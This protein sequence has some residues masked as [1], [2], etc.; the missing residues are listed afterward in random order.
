MTHTTNKYQISQRIAEKRS[1]DWTSA[2]L[3]LLAI[4]V[5]SWRLTAT[6]WTDDLIRIQLLFTLAASLGLALGL[7]RFHRWLAA[8]FTI[9]YGAFFIPWQMGLFIYGEIE[10]GERLISLWGRLLFSFNQLIGGENVEDPIL[11][12]SWLALIVWILG[13]H[14]GYVMSRH[15]NAWLATLPIAAFLVVVHTYDSHF[16]RGIWHLA[17]YMAVALLLVARAYFLDQRKKWWANGTQTSIY[18]GQDMLRATLLAAGLLVFLAWV[19][20][21]IAAEENPAQAFWD[22]ISAPWKDFR[23]EFE[24]A[25]YSLEGA[26]VTVKDYYGETLPLGRGNALASNIVLTAQ[27]IENSPTPPRFYWRDRVYS[28]YENGGWSIGDET[29]TRVDTDDNQLIFEALEGRAVGSVRITSGRN[30]ILLHTPTQPISISRNVDFSYRVNPDGTWDI[31]ALKIPFILRSGESYQVEAYFTNASVLQLQNAGNDYPDW[32]TERYLQIPPEI[33]TRTLELAAEIASGHSN[34]FDI[35]T[36][37]TEWLRENIAYIDSVSVP[38]EGFEPLDWML[39]EKREA[40]CNYYASAQIIMLRSLGIPA[41]MAV[42]YAQGDIA[43]SNLLLGGADIEKENILEGIVQDAQFFTVRQEDAHAWPEVYFPGLG[44]VEFEPT[45][46]Q[47]ALVRSQGAEDEAL[48]NV[49]SD[50]ADSFAA[51]EENE[52]V[53]DLPT[54][55]EERLAEEL[56]LQAANERRFQMI[57][58]FLVIASVIVAILWRRYRERGGKAV[59]VLIEGGINRLDL[60]TPKSLRLWAGYAQLDALPQAFM[61]INSALRRVGAAPIEGDTPKERANQL[62]KRIP[63]ISEVIERLHAQY[64]RSLYKEESIDTEGVRPAKWIIRLA[65]MAE[66]FRNWLRK[67]QEKPQ[68]WREKLGRGRKNK[69]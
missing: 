17:F 7:S 66:Q 40:F 26:P 19:T 12:L 4:L 22:R 36:A 11:F 13:S 37:I 39:F 62:V 65:S 55:L 63:R 32:V 42:G 56:A 31:S 16:S 46:N 27:V 50:E 54:V 47:V 35:S 68:G 69:E 64:E 29:T 28:H 18:I 67:W 43:E 45:V 14:A 49:Q 61:E 59:P 20:P 8:L 44:W 52:I 41:R 30:I 34:A 51:D 24:G 23:S 6:N 25:F 53:N 21:A 15:Q 60:K 58:L 5:A 3:L 33:S 57:V 10:W 2:I 1:W 38:D 9:A 48:V